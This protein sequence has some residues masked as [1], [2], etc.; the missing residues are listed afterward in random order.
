M[1]KIPAFFIVILLSALAACQETPPE[2]LSKTCRDCHALT[3]DAGHRLDCQ[4]CHH[5]ASPAAGAKLA[6]QGMILRPAAPGHFEKN[7]GACHAKEVAAARQSIHFT[8]A[9]YEK[10]R[11]RYGGK[12][13]SSIDSIPVYEQPKTSAELADDLLR[14]RCLRCHL[15]YA[16]E[17]YAATGHGLGCA[18][19]HMR[20][21]DGKMAA[22]QFVATPGDAQCLSCHYGNRVGADYYGFFER[23][24]PPDYRTPFMPE[25]KPPFG[26]ES[27]RLIADIHQRRG[28]ICIDCHRGGELMATTAEKASCAA[29]HDP[30]RLASRLPTGVAKKADGFIFT[31]TNGAEHRLPTLRHEAHGRYGKTA[32]CQVCHAQWAFADEGK[33]FIRIDYDDLEDWRPLRRQ[34]VAELDR[35]LEDALLSGKDPGPPMMSDPFTGDKRAG[36]WL[37][38]YGQRRWETIRIGR[39]RGKLM[40]MRPLADMFLSWVD[41]SGQTRFDNIRLAGDDKGL[42][43][44][45]PHTTGAAGIFWQDLL[46][47]F[48]LQEE[49]KR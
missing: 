36:I 48:Q 30:A 1:G 28:L 13:V 32:D 8:L 42:I 21:Q 22:H 11:A 26:V 16:G 35:L 17:N 44:Y 9:G 12:A 27:H 31:A 20:W 3:L 4:T 39:V 19:C 15:F 23:D 38:A 2:T 37:A 7:C 25:A 14:R 45:T 33:H 29:C 24:L 40:V 18:A 49:N 10:F 5:G 46:R 47:D 41:A 6:H 43:P 34:G